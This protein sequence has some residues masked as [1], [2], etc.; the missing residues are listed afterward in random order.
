MNASAC[1]KHRGHEGAHY[2]HGMATTAVERKLL[3]AGEWVET[4]AWIDVLSPYD[5]SVVGRVPAAGADETRRALDAAEQAMRA[6]AR[7]A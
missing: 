1:G 3:I 7:R 6:A 4:G 5:G 2:T